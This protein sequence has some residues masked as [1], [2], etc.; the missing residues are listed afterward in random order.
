[1]NYYVH[2]MH[3]LGGYEGISYLDDGTPPRIEGTREE[4]EALIQQIAKGMRP[5]VLRQLTESRFRLYTMPEDEVA[6][7]FEILPVQTFVLINGQKIN[8]RLSLGRKVRVSN[9]QR[10]GYNSG[11]GTVV[12]IAYDP[13]TETI[14]Y[15]VQGDLWR[16]LYSVK[17]LMR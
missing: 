7:E 2:Y 15:H 16:G 3:L 12:R 13:T 5:C 10:I 1:M 17:E 6:I 4:A 8:T 11:E 9:P 14:L